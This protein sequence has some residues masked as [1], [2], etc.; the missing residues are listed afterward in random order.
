MLRSVCF[1]CITGTAKKE[2][3]VGVDGFSSDDKDMVVVGFSVCW[4]N[5]DAYYV[6]LTNSNAPCR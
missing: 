4:E 5:R 6:A 2:E 3:P 1:V